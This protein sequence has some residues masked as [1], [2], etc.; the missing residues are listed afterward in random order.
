GQG[1]IPTFIYFL[2]SIPKEKYEASLKPGG[3][4]LPGMHTD[5]YAPLPEPSI[6]TGVRTE[7]LAILNLLGK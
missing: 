3:P 5:A 2:G 6:R 1:G 7:S 4:L